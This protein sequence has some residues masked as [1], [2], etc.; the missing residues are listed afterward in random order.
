M[1]TE[2]K[3]GRKRWVCKRTRGIKEGKGGIEGE[4]RERSGGWTEEGGGLQLKK[5]V[6]GNWF[7][8]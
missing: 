7:L 3:T 8:M 4:V 5:A 1:K 2:S 6:E